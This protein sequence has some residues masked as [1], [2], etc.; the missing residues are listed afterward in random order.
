MKRKKYDI[1]LF[2]LDGTV[3]DSDPMVLATM[4]ILYD[5]YRGGVRTDPAK[6]VYFSGPPIRDT[7]RNEFPDLDNQFIFEQFRDESYK[8]YPTHTSQ[9]PHCRE[10][11]LRLKKDGFKLGVVTNKLHNLSIYALECIDL[12]DIFDVIVGYDDVINPKPNKEGMEKAIAFFNG[13]KERTIYIGDNKSDFDS[14]ENAGIDCCLVNWGP[15]VLPSDIK[16]KYKFNSY[17]ELE[18]ILYE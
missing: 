18:D 6:V 10:V 8:L 3:I 2:D 9:Y 4:N 12:G 17:L 16:P 11:L 13:S 5:K 7:L 1:V 15:R 14:A